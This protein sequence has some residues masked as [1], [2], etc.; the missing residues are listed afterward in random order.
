MI[1]EI[2]G[3]AMAPLAPPLTQALV[4]IGTSYP[5]ILKK[6]QQNIKSILFYLQD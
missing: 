4:N 1:L 6:D 5:D 2:P 3:G